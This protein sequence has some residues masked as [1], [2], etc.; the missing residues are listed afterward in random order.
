M[1]R[2]MSTE[3][4]ILSQGEIDALLKGVDEGAVALAPVPA[5]GVTQSYDIASH[6]RVGHGRLPGLEMANE[7]FI[8]QLRMGINGLLRRDPAI[9]MA[10]LEVL[11]FGEYAQS[12]HVPASL[13]LVKLNPLRGS[14][15]LVFD[16]QLV[17][18][19]VDN[20]FGGSGRSS[21]VEGRE[22]T[23]TESRV[24]QMVLQQVLADLK[25]AWTPLLALQPEYV[26]S[27][28]NPSFLNVAAAADVIVINRFR[29][30]LEGGG[31]ELHVALPYAL[32]EPIRGLLHAGPQAGQ[33]QRDGRWLRQLRAHA[34]DLEIGV[35]PVLGRATL[36]V[37]KL[38]S[39]KSGDMIPCD[40]DGDVTL[41]AE[42]IAAVRG[43]YCSSR[44]K[45]AVQVRQLLL[46][47]GG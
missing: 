11:K 44:G 41:F 8:R 38:L 27:E 35:V 2:T 39:L 26:G 31:G 1:I 23:P 20:F 13:N 14:A 37:E 33:G 5:A 4:E 46:D 25:A 6:V 36:T 16:A 40:F 19:M 29:I 18:A 43:K 24:V 9:S 32:L 34:E 12:L 45:Q 3:G 10:P 30:E 22:F 7:R 15:L 21:S 17:F 28:Q 47:A 42:G